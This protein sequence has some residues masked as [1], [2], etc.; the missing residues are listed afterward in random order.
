LGALERAIE[1]TDREIAR[2]FKEA[3]DGFAHYSPRARHS[4][5]IQA[6]RITVRAREA[7]TLY[8]LG[9]RARARGI[10][11][12]LLREDRLDLNAL[13]NI[14]VCD[15]AN[16]DIAGALTSWRRYAEALYFYDVIGKSPRPHAKARADFHRGFGNAYAPAF[17][18]EKLEAGWADKIDRDAAHSFLGSPGRLRSFVDHKLLEFFNAKLDF[19]SAPLIL[20]VSRNEGEQVRAAAKESLLAFADGVSGLLPERV[21]AAFA[22]TSKRHVE[23]AFAACASA[24]RRMLKKDV[25]YSEEEP[26]QVQ[27]VVDFCH[28]KY[29]LFVMVNSDQEFVKHLS[30]VNFLS[31]FKR[32]DA[33]P[34]GQS[35]EFLTPAAISLGLKEPEELTRFMTRLSGHV[36]FSLLRFIF[37]G[38]GDREEDEL[39]KRQY[40]R[41]LKVWI[42]HEAFADFLDRIDDPQDF[43]PEEVRLAFGTGEID[44]RVVRILYEWHE[45]YPELTGPARLLALALHEQGKS[46][47]TIEVLDRACG[48]GF[49]QKGVLSARVSRMF[50]WYNLG[51]QSEDR[52]EVISC[53]RSS[54][55]DALY[56]LEHGEEGEE[57]TR[58]TKIK[59]EIEQHLERLGATA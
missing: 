45:R 46:K 2:L 47:E 34:L 52:A 37:A 17:L 42:K 24:K 39:R 19:R 15:S 30:S 38:R 40:G 59:G 44:E 51:A 10:W 8:R 53:L 6:L 18:F 12:E 27:L 5:P 13:K 49:H 56:V 33:I 3:N 29:K 26:R 41:L 22:D 35:Q 31:Q 23:E 32:L 28:L 54:L 16:S 14:A 36:V 20:G 57:V 55:R 11:N 9:H 7:E 25:H 58:A 48:L 43:Y 4:P 1:R 50:A 21:R